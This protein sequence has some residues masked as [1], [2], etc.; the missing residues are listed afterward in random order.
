MQNYNIIGQSII[1]IKLAIERNKM[2]AKGETAV[3]VIIV[4]NCILE[5]PRVI[6]KTPVFRTLKRRRV[7]QEKRL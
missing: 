1:E 3:F 6:T 4:L 5:Y 2:T 7:L